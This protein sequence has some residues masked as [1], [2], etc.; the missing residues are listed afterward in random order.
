VLQDDTPIPLS[1]EETAIVSGADIITDTITENDVT[2]SHGD[3]DNHILS[4]SSCV[5]R[6]PFVIHCDRLLQEA[7]VESLKELYSQPLDLKKVV[8]MYRFII[9]KSLIIAQV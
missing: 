9:E 3:D 8:C 1:I 4:A 7:E 5:L 2:G 6:D